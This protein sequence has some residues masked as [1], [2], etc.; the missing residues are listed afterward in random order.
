MTQDTLHTMRVDALAQEK[1]RGRVPEIVEPHRPDPGHRPELHAALRVL[2]Q[3]AIAVSLDVRCTALLAAAAGVDPVIDHAGARERGPQHLLRVRFLRAHPVH[4]HRETPARSSM[5]G[6]IPRETARAIPRSGS[7]P[8][9][10]PSSSRG[11]SRHHRAD[12]AHSRGVDGGERQFRQRRVEDGIGGQGFETKP[13][14]LGT[15]L[16]LAMTRRVLR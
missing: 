15:S 14:P 16:E 2:A 6:A 4:P 3:L 9:A 12:S 11:R 1:R 5:S 8:R 7:R 13:L 10:H